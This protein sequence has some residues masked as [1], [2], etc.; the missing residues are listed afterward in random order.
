MWGMKSCLWFWINYTDLMNLKSSRRQ[1]NQHALSSMVLLYLWFDLKVIF[2][3]IQTTMHWNWEW[4][5]GYL[6][7]WRIRISKNCSSIVWF[8][9]VWWI[10]V[11]VID[12]NEYSSVTTGIKTLSYRR[13]RD[14]YNLRIDCA[15][16]ETPHVSFESGLFEKLTSLSIV[17]CY[18]QTIRFPMGHL[19]SLQE[20]TLEGVW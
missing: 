15:F 8:L 20:I 12:D 16:S 13:N 9:S 1:R 2:N 10:D 11:D 3:L 7:R 17:K 18:C 19:Y 14:N 4:I 5:N 6:L